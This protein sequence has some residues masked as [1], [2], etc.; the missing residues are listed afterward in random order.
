MIR[1]CAWC[2]ATHLPLSYCAK[3][4]VVSYCGKECQRQ[5]WK[6][7]HKASCI[8]TNVHMTFKV[9]DS[10]TGTIRKM[11]GDN[12]PENISMALFVKMTK[13]E[14]AQAIVLF[15]EAT[16]SARKYKL[17]DISLRW[18]AVSTT[19]RLAMMLMA[20][21]EWD[22]AHRTLRAFF[23]LVSRVEALEPS[24]AQRDQWDFDNYISTMTKN[25]ALV[26]QVFLQSEILV[27]RK[28]LWELEPGKHKSQQTYALAQRIMLWQ[29]QYSKL[30]PAYI[31]MNVECRI[32]Q[33]VMCVSVLVDLGCTDA[34]VDN[35]VDTI[36]SFEIMDNQLALAFSILDNALQNYPRREEQISKLQ[37]LVDVVQNMKA[38]V[39][40]GD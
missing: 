18:A 8:K 32:E 28:R 6:Q 20:V 34:D 10:A 7:A 15:A 36:K 35:G 29:E 31:K 19:A 24:E 25:M 26:E 14:K 39:L 23:S 33:V 4:H 12:T 9:V 11:L 38:F 13:E 1:K 22:A 5:H 2:E 17:S 16:R 21:D 3:C 27:T 30:D 37:Y 40:L